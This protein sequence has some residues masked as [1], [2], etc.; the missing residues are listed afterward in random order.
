MKSLT[1]A[2][3]GTTDRS[4]GYRDHERTKHVAYGATG[5]TL[6]RPGERTRSNADQPAISEEG[7]RRAM[8]VYGIRCLGGS[9][10]GGRG[11]ACRKALSETDQPET[12]STQ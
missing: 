12:L 4:R 6:S 8:T 1:V 2:P 10:M 11:A 7:A 3:G 5:S 9:G